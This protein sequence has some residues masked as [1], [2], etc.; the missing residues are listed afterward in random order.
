MVALQRHH[1]LD[2]CKT[3][4]GKFPASIYSMKVTSHFPGSSLEVFLLLFL[5]FCKLLKWSSMGK[6]GAQ[7]SSV[8]KLYY[9]HLAEVNSS[10]NTAI[11]V[12]TVP[13]KSLDT[14]THS[15]AFL[16]LYYFL[17][18]RIKM[19]TSKRRNYTWN[20]VVTNIFFKQMYFRFFKVATICHN[21]SF[22]HSWHSLNQLHEVVTWNAFQLTGVSC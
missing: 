18:C 2:L 5:K 10:T 6:N 16:Y 22:A 1:T 20:L 8:Q 13:V 7:C 15:R 3:R 17:R 19:K 11:M 12:Y 4:L 21:D 9:R 14:P